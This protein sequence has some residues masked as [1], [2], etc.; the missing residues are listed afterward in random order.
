MNQGANVGS[1][2]AVR[3][4]RAALAT[5]VHDAREA[6]LTFE[7]ESRRVLEWLSDGAPRYWHEQARRA[8]DALTEARIELERCRHSKLPGGEPR[9]C[10]EERKNL[11]RARRRR[12]YVEEKQRLTRKWSIEAEREH[13]EYAGRASQLESA[14]DGHFAEAIA[15]LDA[16][17]TALE[18]YVVAGH[19]AT[20][21]G[22]STSASAVSKWGPA[23]RPR[24]EQSASDAAN[25]D[26]ND[27][28]PSTDENQPSDAPSQEPRP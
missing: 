22:S 8:E 2:D 18:S 11:D 26:M 9:S 20:L 15:A 10:L 1:I 21:S 27:Q 12:D 5:F 13:R 24:Y 25:R 7:L 4:F 14:F 3:D 16:S 23:S 19:R 17:L 6:V 28:E